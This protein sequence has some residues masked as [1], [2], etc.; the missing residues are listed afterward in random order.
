MDSKPDLLRNL[1]EMRNGGV[2]ATANQ[3][4]E[5]LIKSVVDTGKPGKMALTLT[6]KPSRV[7]RGEVKEVELGVD[8]KLT[9]PKLDPGKTTFFPYKGGLTRHDPAQIEMFEQQAKET[10]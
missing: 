2:A 6:V 10:K 9:E 1:V 8:I 3:H 7:E 4:W 5:T